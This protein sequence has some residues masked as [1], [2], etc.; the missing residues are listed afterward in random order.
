LQGTGIS[1]LYNKIVLEYKN[2]NIRSRTDFFEG[3]TNANDQY[4]NELPNSLNLK[5]P[6]I[7][8]QAQAIAIGTFELNHSRIDKM[9]TFNCDWSQFGVEAGDVIDITSDQYGFDEKLFKVITVEEI[10]DEDVGLYLSITALEYDANV[11][12]QGSLVKTFRSLRTGIPPKEINQTLTDKDNAAVS[13]V[14]GDSLSTADGINNLTQEQQYGDTF[15]SIPLFQTESFGMSAS[16]VN[17]VYGSGTL[18][19]E[20]FVPYTFTWKS[21]RPLKNGFFF[22][23][24]P[25]GDVTFTVDETNKSIPSLGL[26]TQ[27]KVYAR[28]LDTSTGNGVGDFT[29]LTNRFMEWSSYFTSVSIATDEA[30]EFAVEVYPLNTYDLSATDF[31]ITFVDSSNYIANAN[32]DYATLT[33]FSY[34]Q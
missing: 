30:K 8:D 3:V 10:D 31:E 5:S 6:F 24:A 33:V 25:Q 34:L 12:N 2:L 22:F 4:E 26:P 19:D 11:Y 23:E 27:L 13:K 29:L 17:A 32:G 20:T 28:P 1:E 15:I 7:S 9:I 21:Y 16:D 14:V 18:V